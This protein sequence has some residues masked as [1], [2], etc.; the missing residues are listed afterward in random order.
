M[1]RIRRGG[2][3]I[4][5]VVHYQDQLSTPVPVIVCESESITRGNA[6][7]AVQHAGAEFVIVTR[8]VT[9]HVKQDGAKDTLARMAL[10]VSGLT[11]CLIHLAYRCCCWY[12]T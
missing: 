5:S 12:G 9:K 11:D 7:G 6:S 8:H 1:R 2:R 3:L 4:L 10:V